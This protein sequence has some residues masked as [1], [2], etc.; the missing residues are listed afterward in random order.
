[1]PSEDVTTLLARWSGGDQGALEEL[2]PL[3][4]DELR[5][6]AGRY[7]RRER[8]GH[9]LESTAL[10]HE[11]YLR[12]VDQ[13]VQWQNRSHFFAIAAQLVRR[14]LVD[15]ART[16]D[17]VKRGSGAVKLS[18][19]E[20]L[21]VPGQRDIEMVALD[22]ALNGLAIIDQQQARI[23]ELRFFA[24]LSIEETAEAVGVSPA[25][26]KRDWVMAKAWL[27]REMNRTAGA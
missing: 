18:L 23:V 25:T 20:A 3:V 15:H 2:T 16:R 6:L 21:D 14:I 24:G 4:Y 27:A 9:T 13:K 17:R 10:V 11:A 1:M 12:L 8:A 5:R 7:M 22:D 19:D 26:V